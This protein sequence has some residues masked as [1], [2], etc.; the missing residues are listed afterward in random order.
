M[1]KVEGTS[2]MFCKGPD[3]MAET[4]MSELQEVL[5]L[6]DDGDCPSLN[7]DD[8]PAPESVIQ[9][10]GGLVTHDLDSNSIT[11]SHETVRPFLE[12]HAPSESS[13]H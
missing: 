7:M 8:C 1:E 4:R 5:A 9:V 3:E 2:N 12:S 10:C 6:R 11:F 13:G